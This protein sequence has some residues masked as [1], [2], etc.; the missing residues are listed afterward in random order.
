MGESVFALLMVLV[1]KEVIVFALLHISSIGIFGQVTTTGVK[2]INCVVR[3]KMMALW[4]IVLMEALIG[5]ATSKT[6]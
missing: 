4:F 2:I 5:I 6:T 1:Y 3:F